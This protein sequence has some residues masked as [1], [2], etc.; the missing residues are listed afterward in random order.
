MCQDNSYGKIKFLDGKYHA[1]AERSL[2]GNGLYGWVRENVAQLA[3]RRS[4]EAVAGR[5][6]IETCLAYSSELLLML[7]IGCSIKGNRWHVY[8]TYVADAIPPFEGP[9]E[10]RVCSGTIPGAKRRQTELALIPLAAGVES[11]SWRHG[12]GSLRPYEHGG[13]LREWGW[14]LKRDA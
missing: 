4:P 5:Q 1:L 6:G 9:P 14:V 10:W 2:A 11:S 3:D 8:E 13:C 12:L 7:T